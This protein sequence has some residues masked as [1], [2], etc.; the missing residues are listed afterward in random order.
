MRGRLWKK[1]K[2]LSRSSFC[3]PNQNSQESERNLTW[4]CTENWVHTS[5]SSIS[6][7]LFTEATGAQPLSN[8]QHCWA[9]H[10]TQAKPG[11]IQI[12]SLR[13]CPTA[14][15][16]RSPPTPGY[17]SPRG[18]PLLAHRSAKGL[19]PVQILPCLLPLSLGDRPKITLFN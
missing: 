10:T 8:Q 12:I 18:A 15:R 17:S 9:P 1:L 11:Q 14:L 19:C 3:S 6:T 2:K 7:S 4:L 13:G 5:I 16:T